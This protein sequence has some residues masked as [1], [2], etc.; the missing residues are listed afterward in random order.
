MAAEPQATDTL[1]RLAGG[2]TVLLFSVQPP[3]GLIAR[4]PHGDSDVSRLDASLLMISPSQIFS[5]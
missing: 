1:A 4:R 2:S 5:E 3:A